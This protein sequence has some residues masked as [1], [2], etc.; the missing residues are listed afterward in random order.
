MQLTDQMKAEIDSI[1]K[2][3]TEMLFM[4]FPLRKDTQRAL[5]PNTQNYIT[6]NTKQLSSCKVKL[7][8]FLCKTDLK[9]QDHE[10]LL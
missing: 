1:S 5:T 4:V 3:S 6:K 9:E 7:E 10:N 8:N 2:Y